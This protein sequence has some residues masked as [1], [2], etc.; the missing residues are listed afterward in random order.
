M[1]DII[2]TILHHCDAMSA[3]RLVKSSKQLY[4]QKKKDNN[5]WLNIEF[6]MLYQNRYSVYRLVHKHMGVRRRVLAWT[7]YLEAPCT[8]CRHNLFLTCT[9]TFPL[10]LKLCNNCK[11]DHIMTEDVI[12]RYLPFYVLLNIRRNVRYCFLTNDNNVRTRSYYR[13]AVLR[14]LHQVNWNNVMLSLY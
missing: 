14:Y 5:F 9:N 2:L 1:D 7:S 13:P 3:V 8:L 11:S 6:Q 12:K 10:N 4:Y